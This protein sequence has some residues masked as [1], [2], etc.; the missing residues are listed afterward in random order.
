MGRLRTG[1]GPI[2]ENGC[3]E[4]VKKKCKNGGCVEKREN[5][6]S[7]YRGEKPVKKE[8]H[9]G[10]SGNCVGKNMA[11]GGGGKGRDR[12][13]RGMRRSRTGGARIGEQR[14]EKK[15]VR[16]LPTSTR[17]LPGPRM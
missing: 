10:G 14:P 6:D 12:S 5:P 3:K 17:K 15:G 4:G 1:G 16:G 8:E 9:G 2:R 7:K 13:R 11:K